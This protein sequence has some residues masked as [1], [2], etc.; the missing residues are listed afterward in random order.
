MKKCPFCAEDIQD[1]AVVC[2]FC[3]RSLTA[4][5]EV[6][7]TPVKQRKMTPALIGVGV[8]IIAGVLA[9][10]LQDRTDYP[11]PSSA[12]ADLGAAYTPTRL[13]KPAPTVLEL[14]NSNSTPIGAGQVFEHSFVTKSTD[15]RLTGRVEGVAG[16]EKEFEVRVLSQDDFVN[17]TNQRDEPFGLFI[18]PRQT[19]TTLNVPLPQPGNYSFVVSNHFA[20]FTDKTALIH[21]EVVCGE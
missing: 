14:E 10:R 19:V 12:R 7:R 9:V 20:G 17:W 8:I 13:V 11:T 1:A 21:A 3:G 18:S 15:C 5:P 2:R 4:S 6:S 16:G